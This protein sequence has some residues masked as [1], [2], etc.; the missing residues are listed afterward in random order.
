MN[1]TFS[2]SPM[3]RLHAPLA[4]FILFNLVSGHYNLFIRYTPILGAI[5]FFT[6]LLIIIAP[7]LMLFTIK[8]PV[9]I[10]K[11]FLKMAFS[12]MSDL[13]KKRYMLGIAKL[14]ASLM[15]ISIFISATTGI[16]M[17]F[18]LFSPQSAFEIHVIDSH[19][20]LILIPIHAI[21]MLILNIRKMKSKTTEKT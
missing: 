14:S 15:F 19:V 11:T 1:F 12:F 8:N 2:K 7:L 17:K 4:F 21:I 6:G 20:L 10:L 18:K 13:N 5:H 16:M 3:G 9:K